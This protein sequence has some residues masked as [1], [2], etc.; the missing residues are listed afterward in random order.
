MENLNFSNKKGSAIL[1]YFMIGIVFFF[2]AL[3]LSNPLKEIVT[4]DNV[5]GA[6]GLDCSNASI[7]NQNKAICTG[8]DIM[9]PIFMATVFGLAG[10]LIARVLI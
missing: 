4:S 6:N 9:P 8:I 3:A 1:V 2:L 7:S 5:M 10:I